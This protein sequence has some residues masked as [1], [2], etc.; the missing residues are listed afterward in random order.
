MSTL[1][2]VEKEVPNDIEQLRARLAD[3]EGEV[4]QLKAR[5]APSIDAA[6]IL[7]NATDGF[8]VYNSEFQFTYLNADGERLLG[9]AKAEVL[10]K[11]QWEV[12][13][14]TIGTEIE[15]QYRRAMKERVAVIFESV[16]P[17]SETW[18]EIRVS[19]STMGGLLVWLRDITTR[20][21]AETQREGLLREIQAERQILSEIFE[22]SPVAI[23]VLRAPDFVYEL[24]NPALQALAPGKQILGRRFSDIWGEASAPLVAGLKNVIATGQAFEAIDSPRTIQRDPSAAPETI[25]VTSSWIPLIGPAGSPDRILTLAIETTERKKQ[26]DR[27]RSSEARLARAQRMAN[28]GSWEQDLESGEIQ[29]SEDACRIFGISPEASRTTMENLVSRVHPEDQASFRETIQNASARGGC[30]QIDHRIFLPDGTERYLRQ[31]TEPLGNE[32]GQS[33]LL[34]TVQDVT[35]YKHL[36]EKFRRA[37]RLEGIARLAGGV[38]HDFNNLLMVINNYAHMIL[39]ALNTEDPLRDQAQEII[40]AANRAAA[41]TRQLLAF[42]RKQVIRPRVINLDRLLTDFEKMLRRLIRE[43]IEVKRDLASGLWSV[44]ADPDQVEQVIMNLAVNARDAMPQGG[45]LTIATSNVELGEQGVKGLGDLK[46]GRYVLLTITDSGTGMTAETKRRL[47]EPFFTTKPSGEGTGL[48]L[49]MVYGIVKQHGGELFFVSE[50]GLG[51][52]FKIYWPA[53]DEPIEATRPPEPVISCRGSETILVVEDDEKLRILIRRMLLRQGYKVLETTRS[54]DAAGIA[55]QHDGPIDLLL[56]DVIMPQMSGQALG[57]QL[58]ALRPGIKVI[59]MSGYPGGVTSE[60]GRFDPGAFFLQ[61]PF[62]MDEL[63]Q[64][65]RQVLGPSP[66]STT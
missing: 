57:K 52:T 46:P 50:L 34:G 48:G 28:L 22:K 61:K 45:V 10:G 56:T 64:L 44:K 16:Y 26:E 54:S 11:A 31:Y 36:E 60:Q 55:S 20:R 38:A 49:S 12:F 63:G 30:S 25:F 33:Q 1:A 66:K 58:A 4:V 39:S 65:L 42:S 13:P 27:L 32:A 19:P 2:L 47:F 17:P 51:S 8:A 37:Q 9:K 7:E 43:D 3:L 35:E 53:T 24:V 21:Q 62:E 14:E 59:F 29:L 15:R 41:L 6:S 18:F 5:P 40:H 23:S